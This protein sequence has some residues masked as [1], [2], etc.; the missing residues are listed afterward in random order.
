MAKLKDRQRQIPGGLRLKVSSLKYQSRPFSSFDTIVGEVLRHLRANPWLAKKHGLP[1]DRMGIEQWV[2]SYNAMVCEQQGWLEY[3]EGGPDHQPEAPSLKWMSAGQI[4]RFGAQAAAGGRSLLGWL[5]N[6][7]VPVP[8]EKAEFRGSICAKCPQNSKIELK[9]LFFHSAAELIRRQIE[10]AKDIGLKT[11]HD[12]SLGI[13]NS[14]NC[15]LRLMVHVPLQHKLSN[16]DEESY[17]SLD[18]GCWV[19]LEKARL[20]ETKVTTPESPLSPTK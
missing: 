9:D 1:M 14:C 5:K 18:S 11:S 7:A 15:P 3:I 10:F 16:L 20:S 6:G 8:S 2:D 13:C 19:R 17:N 4:A 12:R